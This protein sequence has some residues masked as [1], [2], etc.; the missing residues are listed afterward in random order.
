ML[1]SLLLVLFMAIF[2]RLTITTES[3]VCGVG[4]GLTGCESSWNGSTFWMSQFLAS[5]ERATPSN[6][7]DSVSRGTLGPFDP[8]NGEYILRRTASDPTKSNP[9]WLLASTPLDIRN[10]IP[11]KVFRRS[12]KY[13]CTGRFTSGGVLSNLDNVDGKPSNRD[14]TQISSSTAAG[15]IIYQ[16]QNRSVSHQ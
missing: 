14:R 16:C 13:Y 11:D 9:T 5:S 7:L 8:V 4:G 6:P 12:H 3:V 15:R 10:C 1:M 2:K